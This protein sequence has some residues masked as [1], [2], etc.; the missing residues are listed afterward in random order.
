MWGVF[1][2]L[3]GGL[4]GPPF[5]APFGAAFGSAFGHHL[6]HSKFSGARYEHV[7]VLLLHMWNCGRIPIFIRW[8]LVFNYSLYVYFDLT[9]S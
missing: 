4:F 8:I 1:G 9:C 7:D 6:W 3:F 5:G 2:E